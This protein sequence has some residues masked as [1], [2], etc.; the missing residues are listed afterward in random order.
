MQYARC[1]CGNLE[2]WSSGMPVT[3]CMPCSKCGTLPAQ[4]PDSHQEPIPHE[5]ESYPVEA[6]QEGVTI[7]RCIHCH[8]TKKQIAKLEEHNGKK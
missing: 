4:G 5:F 2:S 8:R 6:D 3:K 7:S 1:K